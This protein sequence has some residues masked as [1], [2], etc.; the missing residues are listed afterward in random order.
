MFLCVRLP[1]SPVWSRNKIPH[2]PVGGESAAPPS[3]SIPSRTQLSEQA[4]QSDNA[5]V[6][7]VCDVC[8]SWFSTPSGCPKPPLG[9]GVAR[10]HPRERCVAGFKVRSVCRD[11]L[12]ERSCELLPGHAFTGNTNAAAHEVASIPVFG[13]YG[14][15]EA[16]TAQFHRHEVCFRNSRVG[17]KFCR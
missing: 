16:S 14:G 5:I 2:L 10:T 8:S 7:A 4:A 11:S 15:I 9:L 6:M 13:E 12:E 17:R 1:T 3:L